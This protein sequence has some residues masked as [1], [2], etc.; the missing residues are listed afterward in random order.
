MNQLVSDPQLV[1]KR[2]N[3]R[4]TT[5]VHC[6]ICSTAPKN[7]ENRYREDVSSNYSLD[8]LNQIKAALK[9]FIES[10]W[11]NSGDKILEKISIVLDIHGFNVSLASLKK[12]TYASLEKIFESE[13][14]GKSSDKFILFINFSWTSEQVLKSQFFAWFQAM[15]IV[16]RIFLIGAVVLVFSFWS[17]LL[18]SLGWFLVGLVL[19]LVTLRLAVYFRDRDRAANYG[20]FDAIELVRWLHVIL[21]DILDEKTTHSPEEN[22]HLESKKFFGAANLSFISHSMGCFVAT[23]AI[24]V[25]SDVFDSSAIKRWKAYSSDGPFGG[26]K[27]E[28]TAEAKTTEELQKIGDLF[29]L[30]SLVLASPDIPI[31]AITTGRSN[32]LRTC[33]RRFDE[34]YLFTNDADMVLRL[35][36]TVA[37]YFVFP[38]ASRIGGYR[39]GNLTF[40]GERSYGVIRLNAVDLGVRA[41][42]RNIKLTDKP[43]CS[44]NTVYQSFTVVDC[45]DYQDKSVTGSESF[46]RRLSVLT[47]NNSVAN[48]LNYILTAFCHFLGIGQID[49]HGG[50]FRGQFCLEMLYALALYGKDITQA[51]FE[52][53]YDMA[54]EQQ[55]KKHQVAWIETSND[56]SGN[57]AK[58]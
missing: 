40:T 18:H 5:F 46:G 48:L 11:Q 28:R 8:S 50:Y 43:F 6:L 1:I 23:Q 33:L 13:Q 29:R 54:W 15:P 25:L 26:I 56:E 14:T 55:L 21:E 30:K 31:W 20:V 39:L 10:N 37:N 51:Q 47:A 32:F 38:S 58:A 35:A 2:Y 42:V 9:K 45:T 22:K 27:T 17:N 24:R 49:S 12:N 19:C 36:S 34:A 3:P 57:A 16:L 44:Q 4:G 41:F 52:R 53:K 7:A